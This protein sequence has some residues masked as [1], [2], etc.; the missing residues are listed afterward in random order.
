MPDQ[1]PRTS[2]IVTALGADKHGLLAAVAT[3]IAAANANVDDVSQTVTGGMFTMIM[4]VSFATGET[5]MAALQKALVE[6]GLKIGLQITVQHE[7][8]FRYMHRI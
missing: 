7:D 5:T 8:I 1:A 3:T 2:V 4:F 6:T